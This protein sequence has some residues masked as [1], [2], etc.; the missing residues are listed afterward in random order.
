MATHARK[1]GCVTSGR[2][3]TYARAAALAFSMAAIPLAAQALGVGQAPAAD[4]ATM[5]PASPQD[6][7]ANAVAGATDAALQAAPGMYPGVNTSGMYVTGATRSSAGAHGQE[8]ASACGAAA[9]QRTVVVDLAFP[10]ML[11]SASKSQGTLYVSQEGGH[12][13]AWEAAH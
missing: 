9:Q 13:H 1:F 11:P 7:P 5:C 2:G 8:I 6:L 12:Y 10:A 3:G 4:A